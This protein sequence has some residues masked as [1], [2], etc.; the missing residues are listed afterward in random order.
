MSN[1]Q[2]GNFGVVDATL[3]AAQVKTLHSSPVTLLDAPGSGLVINVLQVIYLLAFGSVSFDGGNPSLEL[4]SLSVGGTF[5]NLGGSTNRIETDT[6]AISGNSS[7]SSY[8]NQALKIFAA[9]DSTQGDSTLRVRVY[10]TIEP[11]L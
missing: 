1:P 3:S 2:A 7:S 4:G 5:G 6:A 9:T 8:T 11:S 10:Y